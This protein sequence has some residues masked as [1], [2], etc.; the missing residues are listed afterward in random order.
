MAWARCAGYVSAPRRHQGSQVGTRRL[1]N[2]VLM[3]MLMMSVA[4]CDGSGSTAAPTSG[5]ASK[6]VRRTDPATGLP[7]TGP[8]QFHRETALVCFELTSRAPTPSADLTSQVDAYTRAADTL[9]GLTDRTAADDAVVEFLGARLRWLRAAQEDGLGR[10]GP[11]PVAPVIAESCR[12]AGA[13]LR[14]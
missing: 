3:T 4:A 5:S 13:A 8:Q 12:I 6:P 9:T 7:G 14:R 1:L 2:M 11:P 10:A